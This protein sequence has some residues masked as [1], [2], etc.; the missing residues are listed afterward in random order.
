MILHIFV[1]SLF[2][3][4]SFAKCIE[5]PEVLLT[6]VQIQIHYD[7]QRDLAEGNHLIQV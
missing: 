5:F 3:T 6:Q 1:R 2:E 7:L 4:R